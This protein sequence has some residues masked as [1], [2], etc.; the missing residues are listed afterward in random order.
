MDWSTRLLLDD[1][2]SMPY[3]VSRANVVDAH[4]DQVTSAKFAVDCQIE[5]CQ[6]ALG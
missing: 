1:S 5:E 4:L 6:V 2:R 3:I